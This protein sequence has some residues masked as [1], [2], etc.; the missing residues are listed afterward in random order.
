MDKTSGGSTTRTVTYYPVAGAMRIDSTLYYILKDHLGSAS[1]VTDASGN[2]VGEDRFYPFGETRLTTG[3]IYTDRLFTGQREMAGL[4]IYNYGARFYSPKLGR[5]LSADTLVP[6][7]RNPQSLNRYSYVRNSP[8][9]YIDPSGH[10]EC[11]T[12]EECQ[13]MGTT[14]GGG[15]TIPK[16]KS[17]GG[18]DGSGGNNGGG[19]GTVTT[20]PSTDPH[21][22]WAAN[23]ICADYFWINCTDAEIYDYMSRWQ[24]P[25]QF[26]WQPVEVGYHYNVIPGKFGNLPLVDYF[27]PG[28]GSIFVEF[29]SLTISNV[30]N[31]NHIFYEGRV[32]RTPIIIN[33][34]PYVITHGTGTNDGFQLGSFEVGNWTVDVGVPGSWID[35][36]NNQVGPVTFNLQDAGL[37]IYTTVVETWQF[38]TGSQQSP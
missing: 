34:T 36:A 16:T 15:F 14:P 12:Q 23:P 1:V 17:G 24:Y 29:N 18:G 4:G 22:Y 20:I 27:Y 7:Y 5:F 6:G 11:R 9:N 33:G 30:A 10:V 2:T 13:D 37:L 32:D 21:D 8:L 3:T 31:P 28:S 25:G 35:A 19:P 38:I 26:F